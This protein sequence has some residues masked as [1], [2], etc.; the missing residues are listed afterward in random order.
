MRVQKSVFEVRLSTSQFER[1]I[2]CLLEEIDT[3]E[4][5]VLIYRMEGD[6]SLSRMQLGRTTG[7]QLG[8]PWIF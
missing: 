1:L 3:T 8:A 6:L 2:V 4:D 7:H 5:T